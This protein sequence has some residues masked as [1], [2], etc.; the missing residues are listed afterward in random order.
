MSNRS[1]FGLTR[2][3]LIGVAL[4]GLALAQPGSIITFDVPGAGTGFRQGTTATSI[5][6]AGLIT[7]YYVDASNFYHGFV[8]RP[9]AQDTTSTLM[10]WITALSGAH[11]EL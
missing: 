9:S 6:A 8:R 10:G 1:R 5:N 2:G 3:C 4:C 11:R 7:G